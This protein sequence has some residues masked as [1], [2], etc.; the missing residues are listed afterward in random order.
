MTRRWYSTV[1]QVEPNKKL[2]GRNFFGIF[3]ESYAYEDFSM[4]M[5]D[6]KYKHNGKMSENCHAPYNASTQNLLFQE[7]G[8]KKN[9]CWDLQNCTPFA[10]ALNDFVS[11]IDF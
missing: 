10:Q 4:M 1:I 7:Y 5:Y 6:I 9:R 3:I 8:H 2:S 11:W